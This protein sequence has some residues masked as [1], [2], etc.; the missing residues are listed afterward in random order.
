M[1]RNLLIVGAGQYG[2]LAREIAEEMQSFMND[3]FELLLKL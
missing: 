1:K 2:M 3:S